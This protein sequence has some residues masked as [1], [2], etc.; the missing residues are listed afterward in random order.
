MSTQTI[1]TADDERLEESLYGW[2][3]VTT[4]EELQ[5]GTVMPIRVHGDEVVLWRGESGEPHALDAY[6]SHLGHHMGYG[7]R[8]C[9]EDVRCFYHGWTWSPQGTNTDVPYDRRT[10]KG[11]RI[12]PWAAADRGGL[13]YVWHPGSDDK[14]SP[15]RPAPE[16]DSAA[17]GFAVRSDLAADP[18]LIV[19]HFVDPITLGCFVGAQPLRSTITSVT[20]STFGIQHMFDDRPQVTVEIHDA[21]TVVVRTGRWSLLLGVCPIAPGN[22]RVWSG[23]IEEGHG[24]VGQDR[25]GVEEALNRA[26]DVAAK[27]ALIQSPHG[28]GAEVVV[29]YRQW[30]VG[31]RGQ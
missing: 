4:S 1:S 16:F 8:V 18:R 23:F 26:L 24:D 14:S 27:M 6:C 12:P 13:I 22:T 21:A 31:L 17:A 25:Q 2:L 20:D 3:P 5:H 15:V 28:L 30:V 9:G 11:R 7:G 29:A 10:Y 19:E